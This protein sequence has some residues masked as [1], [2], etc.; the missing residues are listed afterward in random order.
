[1][2]GRILV[3][4]TGS[5][6]TKIGFYDSEKSLFEENIVHPLSEL[7]KYESVMDQ[8]HMRRDAIMD[9]LFSRGITLESIDLVMA[10]CGLV[11]PIETGVYVINEDMKEALRRG[12][13]GVHACNLCAIVADDLKDIITEKR[14]AAGLPAIGCYVA[15]PPLANEMLPEA[16]LGGHPEF[17]RWPLFHA[18]NSRAVARRFAR[19]R[20]GQYEDYTV[21]I[22]HMGGGTSVTLHHKGRVI[23]SNQALGGDGPMSPDR[24]GT[25]LASDLVD[26]CFSGKYTKDEVKK[27]LV[28]RGGAVAYFGTNS[29]KEVAERAEAGDKDCQLF[30]DAYVLQM[31]KYIAS[32]AAVVDGKVDAVI[33]TGGIAYN[34]SLMKKIEKRTG[35]IAPIT[36]VPGENELESLAENGYGVLS[37]E[38]PI[39]T[40]TL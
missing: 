28:G 36:V 13:H 10:R 15:D 33:L 5:T 22:A 26:V 29:F 7:E 18:L 32:L 4:N 6:S 37:G 14:L 27:M 38:F 9:S 2:E 19:A 31:G 34:A 8:G 12:K 23:D 1:M 30:L 20:N 25:V 3:I 11:A 24:T 16:R 40:F 17:P 21:I 35:W 39:K